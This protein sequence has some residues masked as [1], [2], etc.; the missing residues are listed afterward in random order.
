MS[1]WDSSS[2]NSGPTDAGASDSG[3]S[4]ANPSSYADAAGTGAVADSVTDVS[5]RSW[6][7][8]VGAS[9]VGVLFG[10]AMVAG[11]CVLLYWNEQRAVIALR[12]LDDGL[13][14][15]REAP[16]NTVDPAL[17]GQLVH[18][19]ARL[20]ATASAVDPLFEIS[21]PNAIRLR[22]TVEMYQWKEEENTVSERTAGGGETRRTTFSYARVWSEAPISSDGFRAPAGHQNPPMPMRNQIFDSRNARLGAYNLDPGVMAR[23]N[24][25]QPIPPGAVTLM[26]AG[27]QRHA[28]Y[29]Y[30]GADMAAPRVGDLR[31]RLEGV[32][33]GYYSVVAAQRRGILVPDAGR[34]GYAIALAREGTVGAAQMFQEQEKQE[35]LLTWVLRGVGFVVMLLGFLLVLNPLAVLVG[36]LPFLEAVVSAGLFFIALML[37]LP[38]SL[39]VIAVSWLAVRPVIGGG[40]LVAALLALLVL[41]RR[42]RNRAAAHRAGFA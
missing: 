38:I 13:N 12:A 15:V 32:A 22:R 33:P 41:L 20:L 5:H 1:D 28:D 6:F 29:L 16:A 35:A 18:V 7:A 40:L 30:R 37:A 2:A 25:F 10:I 31:V 42:N 23:I 11:G 21:G 39:A 14:R 26:P 17:D 34:G 4:W 27:F 8:R 9:L 19:S 24:A 3:V 36:V